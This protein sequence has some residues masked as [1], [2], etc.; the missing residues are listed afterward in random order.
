[1]L[2]KRTHLSATVIALCAV[3]GL[4]L[5]FSVNL[6][7]NPTAL[8]TVWS[9]LRYFTILTNLMIAIVFSRMAIT[10]R[11]ATQPVTAALA[12]WI[13]IVGV[14]YWGLLDATIEPREG[15]D[16]LSNH[17]VHTVTPL[18]TV[19]WWIAFAEK[20]RL[21]FRHA[22]MWLAWPLGYAIYGVGRGMMDGV[23]PYFFI[24]PNVLGWGGVA[25]WVVILA[26][27]FGI[28]AALQIGVARILTRSAPLDRARSDP[29]DPQS[30]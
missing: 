22:V 6:A 4:A 15:A 17:M 8:A 7:E 14:V 10:G 21:T 27:S 9:L 26:L 30:R 13:A 29:R 12:L 24:D 20:E 19:L 18:T 23:Y 2:S 25:K 5:Q 28:A 11:A 16:W 3:L 1:M